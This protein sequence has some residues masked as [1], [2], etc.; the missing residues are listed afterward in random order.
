LAKRHNRLLRDS[1][2]SG[3][4]LRRH[5]GLLRHDDQIARLMRRAR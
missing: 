2:A 3:H 5:I 4:R 1:G